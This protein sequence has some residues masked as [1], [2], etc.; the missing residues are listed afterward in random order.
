VTRTKRAGKARST[1]SHDDAEG[2]QRILAVALRSFAE[3][4]YE[5]T[6]TAAVAREVGVTQPLVHHHFGSKEGLWRA[7]MHLLFS[8]LR[9]FTELDRT[10]PPTR[11]LLQVVEGFVRL[12]AARRS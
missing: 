9:L 4:G 1:T 6:T 2:R 5:G 11:A 10:L 3:L 12:S 7:A 8:E